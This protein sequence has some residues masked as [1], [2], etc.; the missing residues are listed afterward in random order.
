MRYSYMV[1]DIATEGSFVIRTRDLN[2]NGTQIGYLLGVYAPADKFDADLPMLPVALYSIQLN[3][4][5]Q[6]LCMSG[7]QVNTEILVR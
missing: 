1:N 6:D 7:G 4:Y 3:P 5:Y 2:G